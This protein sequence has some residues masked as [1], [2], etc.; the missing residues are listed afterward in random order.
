MADI[1]IAKNQEI[2][3]TPL[4]LFE[5]RLRSGMVERW[6]THAVTIG[7]DAYHPR[8]LGHNLFDLKASL[9]DGADT[10][11]RI[12][13]TLANA[14]SYFSQVEWN[15]GWKGARLSVRFA[16]VDLA[17]GAATTTPVLL[18]QGTANSADEITESTGRVTFTNRL[19]LQ[20]VG[21]PEIR[22]Q[23]RCPWLFPSTPEQRQEAVNGGAKGRYSPFY[24]C[25]YS[26]DVQ[27]GAGNTQPGG[28]CFTSCDYSR[29]QCVERGM[30]H[31]DSANNITSRFGGLEFVPP[32]VLVRGYGEKS[33]HLSAVAE[34]ETR[35]N[36][37]VPVVYGTAWYQPPV[38]FARNDGNLT[39]ME[40]LLAAGEIERV[41]K[42]IVNDVEIPEAVANA[43]MTGTGW[44]A[45]IS[46]GTP[47]GG[48]NPDFTGAD[49]NPAGD[50]YGSM[51]A[52]SVVVPNRVSAGQALP[53][54]QVL[55]QGL[56]L[57]RYDAQANALPA[58]FTNNPA[59]VMLDVL[60]RSGWDES[61]LDLAS[62]A[63]VA[64]FCGE[65]VQTVDVHG[66]PATTPRFQ[67]NLVLRRRRSAADVV[68]GVRNGSSLMLGY[69]PEGKLRL[70]AEAALDIQQSAKP[71]TSNS[72]AQ[73]NGGWPAFEFSDGSA[74]HSGILR[75]D[76]GEPH[77]RF[78]SRPASET[79]NRLSVEFQDE[80]NEYQQDSLSL[81]DIDD[82]VAAGQEISAG[83]AALGLP[84]FGQAA[85]VARLQLNKFVAGNLYVEFAT[86]VRGFGLTPGDIIAIT[87]EKEGLTRQPFRIVRIAPGLNYRTVTITAQIHDDAWYTGAGASSRGSRRQ[88]RYGVGLPRPLSAFSVSETVREQSDGGSSVALSTQFD[89]PSKPS[90]TLGIPLL[91]LTPLLQTTGGTIAGNQALYYAISAVDSQGA[92]SMLSFSVKARIPASTDSNAV[93]LQDLSFSAGTASFNVYR[94][95]T[96]DELRRI[97]THVAVS[98]QFT[99]TGLVPEQVIGPP[100]ENYDHANFYWRFEIQPQVTATIAAANTI[101]SDSLTMLANENRGMLVRITAGKGKGQERLVSANSATTLTVSPSWDVQ[102]D[103][104]SA[105]VIAE[106]SWRFGALTVLGPAEFEVPNRGGATV[107][108]LGRSANV[109]DRECAAEISPVVRWHIGGGGAGGDSDVPPEPIFGFAP[110]GRG[111]VELVGVGFQSLDNTTTITAGTLTVYCWNE[112]ATTPP[113]ALAA[114]VA[115]GDTA[116]QIAGGALAEGDL[117]QIDHE[118]M[119][120]TA[121]GVERGAYS[122]AIATHAIGAP[123]YQLSRRTYIV[124]FAPEFFG[125]PA[126]GSYN[127]PIHLP[128]VRIAAAELFVTNSHGNSPVSRYAFTATADA[129]IRTLSGGQFSIQVDGTL[130]IQTDAA[131]PLIVEDAHAVRDIYAVLRE[132]PMGAPVELRVK[133][134]A[135]TYCD[136]TVAPGATVS[137]VVSGFGLPPLAAQAQL[138]LDIVSV[139]QNP[140]WFPGAGVTVTLRL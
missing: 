46:S 127:Y 1:H 36:D 137:N 116:I 91:S 12:A 56:K 93:T 34:N 118:V 99:D 32:S 30:F 139:P 61:S 84:N 42:V 86:S 107:H 25:G 14:D 138:S 95:T 62:F 40:V 88:P 23:K 75:K 18:F 85:R 21:L 111:S 94:G 52:L 77:I 73:L 43:N 83:I 7:G 130:A 113:P 81:V 90:S 58:A 11:A 17:A 74:P 55:I 132:P 48:F 109:H 50:P 121:E 67:C 102:P 117:I 68:R 64:Q 133:H 112:L 80:F 101:G 15:G 119:A 63:A 65:P 39:R 44:Y 41:V 122:S 103:S 66:N 54:V 96:P 27:G 110:T 104:T 53:R 5:C 28:Q 16:L 69:G 2:V 123:V 128:D 24:R 76:N 78:W 10:A 38:V 129:G 45:L 100:D 70:R 49:G 35:Y 114:A 108:I 26:P 29:V 6:S 51:A 57:P 37:F 135:A 82:A 92:E 22:V 125:S 19:N 72:T 8:V 115:I 59:W 33:S 106:P 9:D 120:V 126:S 60:R 4:F 131:P 136:L 89:T 140:A 105:F 124:P 20:R 87:Y 31:R 79:P 97:S 3:D 47:W 13:L 134:G 71:V 98:S